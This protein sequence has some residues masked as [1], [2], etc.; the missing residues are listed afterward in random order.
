MILSTT[1]HSPTISNL[2]VSISSRNL[3]EKNKRDKFADP[4]ELLCISS[5]VNLTSNSE[6]GINPDSYSISHHKHKFL[7]DFKIR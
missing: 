6:H 5:H 2:N 7:S 4:K 3:L 1:Q